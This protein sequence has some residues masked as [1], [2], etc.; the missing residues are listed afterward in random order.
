MKREKATL[1]PNYELMQKSAIWSLQY[2]YA[3]YRRTLTNL[4]S[5]SF[6]DSD[7]SL[8]LY[9]SYLGKLKEDYD[10]LKVCSKMVDGVEAVKNIYF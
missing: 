8:C 5:S 7:G 3:N 4:F 9:G 10:N 2:A 1:T 6:I